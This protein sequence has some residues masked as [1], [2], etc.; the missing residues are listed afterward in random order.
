MCISKIVSSLLISLT[1]CGSCSTQLKKP[2]DHIECHCETIPN[3]L[4]AICTLITSSPFGPFSD[5]VFYYKN[6]QTALQY[7][8]SETGNVAVFGGIRFSTKGLYL[9]ESWY[10]EGHPLISFYKTEDYVT[11]MY[12]EG[13]NIITIIDDYYFDR[14]VEFTDDGTVLYSTSRG[15]GT[16]VRINLENQTIQ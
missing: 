7:I 6:D 9:Y 13:N 2:L 10:E 16:I 11:G 15:D 1:F 14:I 8:K 12:D 5:V 3:S 4:N